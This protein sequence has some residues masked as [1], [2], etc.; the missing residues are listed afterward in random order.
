MRQCSEKLTVSMFS[1]KKACCYFLFFKPLSVIAVFE[2]HCFKNN[3]YLLNPVQR[4]L[5]FP[6]LELTAA[7]VQLVRAFVSHGGRLNVRT[8]VAPKQVVTVPLL[9]LGNGCEC[10]GSSEMTMINGC[11]VSQQ[12]W[13]AKEPSFSMT[14]KAD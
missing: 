14:M 3:L 11:P 7:V 12:V 2:C 4:I 8:L 13:Q 5:V 9:T 6:M 10:H 1:L